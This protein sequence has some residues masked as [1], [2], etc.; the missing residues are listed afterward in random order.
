MAGRRGRPPKKEQP[1]NAEPEQPPEAQPPVS[2]EILRKP[3]FWERLR[4]A[5]WRPIAP[6]WALVQVFIQRITWLRALVAATVFVL[7]AVG[8][9]VLTNIAQRPA[10]PVSVAI[11]NVVPTGAPPV[12]I[13]GGQTQVPTQIS[14]VVVTQLEPV[15]TKETVVVTQEREMVTATSEPPTAT[16][17]WTPIAVQQSP[18]TPVPSV[19][20]FPQAHLLYAEDFEDG[21]FNGWRHWWGL[22]N[23]VELPDGNHVLHLINGYKAYELPKGITTDY[24]LEVRAMQVSLGGGLARLHLR[25]TPGSNCG[26]QYSFEADP[27]FDWLTL[28]EV[29][30]VGCPGEGGMRA[31]YPLALDHQTW[32][33]LRFETRGALLRAYVNGVLYLEE[34][35]ETYFSNMVGLSSCCQEADEFYFDDIRVWTFAPLG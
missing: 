18:A 25:V 14:T 32:Y 35:S 9:W 33:T 22:M 2:V 26:D 10:S 15:V 34:A 21:V 31:G 29:E 5:L 27:S 8:I 24:V 6:I 30:D 11:T 19:T 28:L 7:I 4:A 23:V 13:V 17:T 3:T 16:L 20:P 1:P 12:V